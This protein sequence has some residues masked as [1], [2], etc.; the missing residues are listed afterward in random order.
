[1]KQGKFMITIK[2]IAALTH[3]SPSTVSIV[4]R[5]NGDARKISKETQ[6]RIIET[7]Q[8]LGYT[9]N[10]QAK[11]LREGMP[12]RSIITLFWASDIRVHILS[13]FL[14]GLQTSLFLH[15]YHC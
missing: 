3:I 2:D 15:D 8:K 6:T 10:I 13:R 7:A 4:L 9:P 5:G 12:A 14:N 11:V 1:M